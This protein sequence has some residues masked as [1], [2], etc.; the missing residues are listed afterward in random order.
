MSALAL[1]SWTSR[2]Q[3]VNTNRQ[4]Y[5]VMTGFIFR[6][7]VCLPALQITATVRRSVRG[8]LRPL[9]LGALW[10][11]A[12]SSTVW[13]PHNCANSSSEAQGFS[14]FSKV[15]LGVKKN[16]MLDIRPVLQDALFQTL[17]VNFVMIVKQNLHGKRL[18]LLSQHVY[19]CQ[20]Q[21]TRIEGNRC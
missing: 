13:V 11:K 8:S 19:F 20:L 21:L 4:E 16:L 5:L 7:S 9:F 12:A 3:W 6:V 2:E 15:S 1:S 10:E 18:I 17:F 14:F